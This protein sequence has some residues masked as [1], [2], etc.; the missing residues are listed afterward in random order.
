MEIN[1]P[2]RCFR[3][4]LPSEYYIKVK[5]FVLIILVLFFMLSI[6]GCVTLAD[7]NSSQEYASDTVGVLDAQTNLGQSFVSRRP[8][9]NGITI[10][11]TTYSGQPSATTSAS[12]NNINV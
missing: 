10:W 1:N 11:L 4:L 2:T 7:F 12:A 5:T 8:N 6:S 9:L 3:I